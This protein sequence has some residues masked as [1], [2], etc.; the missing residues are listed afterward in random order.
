LS[1][2]TTP[3]YWLV[4]LP[5]THTGLFADPEVTGGGFEE[6]ARLH[7]KHCLVTLILACRAIAGDL[8]GSDIGQDRVVVRPRES[9]L[10]V[11][12][13]YIEAPLLSTQSVAERFAGAT[14]TTDKLVMEGCEV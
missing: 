6:E 13:Q 5:K 3:V 14:I 12:S 10:S 7:A 4:S 11:T 1:Y 2:W 9:Q 8:L